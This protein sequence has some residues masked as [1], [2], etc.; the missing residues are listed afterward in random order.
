MDSSLKELQNKS[1]KSPV[2]H[3]VESPD[4]KSMNASIT[5]S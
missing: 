4:Q 2:A 5:S 3:S 1:G